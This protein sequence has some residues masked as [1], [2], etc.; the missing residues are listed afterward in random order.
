M[1]RLVLTFGLGLLTIAGSSAAETRFERSLLMLTPGER[2]VQLCDFTAMQQIRKEHPDFRP[3]RVV[4]D[5]DRDPVID[6]DTVIAKGGAF[7]SRGKWYTL[8]FHCTAAPDEMKVKSFKYKI[9]AEIPEDKWAADGL[10]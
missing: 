5:G 3:D 4:A 10:W 7:R 2:L 9:G 1:L 6:K 8:T